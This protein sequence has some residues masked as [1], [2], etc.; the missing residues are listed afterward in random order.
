MP[1]Q[2]HFSLF[3][4]IG[5]DPE[6]YQF[7]IGAKTTFTV[8]TIGREQGKEV[9][10]Y[11]LWMNRRPT[12]IELQNTGLLMDSVYDALLAKFPE[13]PAKNLFKEVTS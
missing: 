3:E 9:A 13:L 6:Y 4:G 7:T 5:R 8:L 2:R 10:F 11:T 12:T 1:A